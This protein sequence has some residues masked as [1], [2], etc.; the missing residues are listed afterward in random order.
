M[1]R[2]AAASF[3]L[4]A[5]LPPTAAVVE[6]A[7]LSPRSINSAFAVLREWIPQVP[8]R[9]ARD[10]PAHAHRH[11]GLTVSPVV[12]VERPPVR[13]WADCS[14][15]SPEHVAAPGA[16]ERLGGRTTRCRSAN[17]ELEARRI[18]GEPDAA[19]SRRR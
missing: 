7:R 19:I 1:P 4:I 13:R 3:P 5:A 9:P 10:L 16:R 15:P 2:L 8:A 12:A 17:A 11:W 6:E 18:R 14:V